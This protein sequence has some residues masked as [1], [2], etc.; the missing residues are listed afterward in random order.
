MLNGEVIWQA[1]DSPLSKELHALAHSNHLHDFIPY[2]IRRD[3]GPKQEI[4]MLKASI[5]T[6]NKFGATTLN[7]T[8]VQKL[9]MSFFV[10]FF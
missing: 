3:F 8:D 10:F 4:H 6:G 9:F 1:S 7:H 2:K 5:L